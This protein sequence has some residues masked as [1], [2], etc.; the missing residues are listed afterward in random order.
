MLT[1]YETSDGH[2]TRVANDGGVSQKCVWIDLVNPT[3][4]EDAIIEKALGIAIPTREEMQEIE[5]S[6]RIYSE[7]GAHYMT[8][9]LLHQPEG[10]P[11]ISTPVTFILAG[12]RLVTVR[13]AE[14]RAFGMY[15]QR[16]QKRE[17]TSGIIDREAD[18][19]EKTSSEVDLLGSQIFAPKVE[20]PMKPKRQDLSLRAI[21]REGDLVS[22]SRESL[23]SIDRVLTFAHHVTTERGDDKALRARLKTASRD[24]SSLQLHLDSLSQKVQF[25]LDALLGMISIEQNNII[26]IFSIA[27]VALMPPTLIASIY[28]MNFKH[29]PELEWVQ[30]Y[31]M[32]LVLMLI[33]AMLPF[34]FFKRKGWY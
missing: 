19:V 21:G 11:A 23:L 31:P 25:L 16:V 14:P 30:G 15:I 24:I 3:R 8:A 5:A 17:F 4:E 9:I 10:A 22:R 12:H 32:A 26:K 1:L 2:L 34:W 20:R 18:R 13:Y 29:M 28:G 6:S 33:A 27:S 7:G